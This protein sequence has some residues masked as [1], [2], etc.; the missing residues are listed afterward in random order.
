LP[1]RYKDTREKN[2]A[3]FVNIR[4]ELKPGN[5]MV[6]ITLKKNSIKVNTFSQVPFPPL[7]EPRRQEW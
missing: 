4:I 6:K 5:H 2:M 3:S 1:P 7:S